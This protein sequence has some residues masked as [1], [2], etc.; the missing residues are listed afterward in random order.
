MSELG[1]EEYHVLETLD[2]KTCNTCG[3]MDGR[4]FPMKEYMVGVTAPPFHPNCRGTTCPYLDEESG[5]RA[6]RGEDGKT[7]Y[8]PENMTY[9]EW[10]EQ[11]V[12]SFPHAL[13]AYT[14]EKNLDSDKKQYKK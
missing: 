4:H 9:E 10:F 3:D 13:L 7:Y 11:Y 14:K 6:A 5:E 1:V 12:K 8:V 2:S